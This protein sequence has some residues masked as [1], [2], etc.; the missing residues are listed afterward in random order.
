VF[1]CFLLHFEVK[2]KTRFEFVQKLKRNSN[3]SIPDTFM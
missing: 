3:L 2:D 1:D